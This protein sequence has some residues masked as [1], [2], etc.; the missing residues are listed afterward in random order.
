MYLL[1]RN[2]FGWKKVKKE[3]N[4]AEA[5]GKHFTKENISESEIQMEEGDEWEIFSDIDVYEEVLD[6]A[7]ESDEQVGNISPEPVPSKPALF[8][9][10]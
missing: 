5:L 9:I 4:F 10:Y 2:L 3:S 1:S 6:T 7:Q 8:C